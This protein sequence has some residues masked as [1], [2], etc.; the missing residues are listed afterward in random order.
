MP[1]K[2]A[3]PKIQL[4]VDEFV[5][6][7]LV[8]TATATLLDHAG[9]KNQRPDCVAT[10]RRGDLALQMVD[11]F[12]PVFRDKHRSVRGS[13]EL[14]FRLRLLRFTVLFTRRLIASE[15]SLSRENVE[16][17]RDAL[18]ARTTA[19][20]SKSEITS[21]FKLECFT[22]ELPVAPEILR[23]YRREMLSAVVGT[24]DT[25]DTYYGSPDSLS[26]LDTLYLFMA[27]SA[28]Y[29][30]TQGSNVTSQ[31]MLLAADYMVAAVLEQYLVYGASGL[32]PLREAFAYGFDMDSKGEVGSD[33]LA[34]TNMFWGGVDENEVDGWK[35][36]RDEH[37]A[38]LLPSDG[39]TIQEHLRTLEASRRFL[40][41]TE[42]DVLDF[43]ERLH[44]AQPPPVLVQLEQG[45]IKGLAR[46]GKLDARFY[47][48]F[49]MIA[50]V[51][52]QPSIPL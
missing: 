2:C 17:L 37:L 49:P 46:Y 52:Q 29:T 33:E 44:L 12:L 31:W 1:E 11:A 41:K 34:I 23:G 20:L 9:P 51:P 28:H 21:R 38:A 15:T 16:D 22:N 30:M 39:D 24:H 3:D 26:L 14:Q 13:R 40:S 50:L 19:Y 32:E 7:Y 48:E 43:L 45:E 8:F 4:E 5:L 27:L 35:E 47:E 10:D 36:I 18:K 42:G 25:M 6:D